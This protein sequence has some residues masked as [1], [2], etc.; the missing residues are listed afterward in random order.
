MFHYGD[1]VCCSTCFVEMHTYLTDD[2][3]NPIAYICPN[4]GKLTDIFDEL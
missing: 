4:C 1:T 3:G 2:D